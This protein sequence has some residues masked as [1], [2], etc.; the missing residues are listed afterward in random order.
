MAKANAPT[1]RKLLK[2]IGDFALLALGK[3][4][5]GVAGRRR[6]GMRRYT[7]VKEKRS[8]LAAHVLIPLTRCL[9]FLY[10]KTGSE[11]HDD[12][13]RRK[14]L[15]RGTAGIR[16][17]WLGSGMKNTMLNRR[18]VNF[19]VVA[20]LTL[21]FAGCTVAPDAE[22]PSVAMTAVNTRTAGPDH[23]QSNPSDSPPF[24]QFPSGFNQFP[25]GF[26]RGGY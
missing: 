9:L 26:N 18:T 22:N 4:A 6:E 21:L 11:N 3:L 13:S 24:N 1:T 2:K 19:T 20:L 23:L 16:L 17:H 5:C 12:S 14:S 25:S 8:Q 7:R 15:I 10:V